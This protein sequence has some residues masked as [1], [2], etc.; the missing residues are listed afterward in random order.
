MKGFGLY[1]TNWMISQG[2]RN[3]VLIT[4]E[5]E[6]KSEDLKEIYLHQWKS[7]N[8]SVITLKLDN[9]SLKTCE[10]LLKKALQ[11]GPVGGV[12]DFTA[13]KVNFFS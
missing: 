6:S 5:N 8:T 11:L 9:F 4:Q 2:V 10:A 13:S 12:F 3:L 1:V 7:S